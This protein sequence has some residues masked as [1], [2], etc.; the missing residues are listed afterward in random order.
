MAS[1]SWFFATDGQQHGPYSEDQFR[2]LIGRGDI[3]PDTYVWSEGMAAWQFAGD[4]P[5]LLSSGAPAVSQTGVRPAVPGGQGA[6]AFSL[7]VGVGE[8]LWRSLVLVVG[9]LLIIPVPW[10][11]VWYWRWFVSRVH[12]RQWPNLGFTGRPMDIW[13][14][15]AAFVLQVCATLIDN[16]FLNLFS[17]AVQL[18]LYWLLLR[19]FIANLSSNGQPLSLRFEGSFWG[20]FG[21]NILF[22]VSALTIIGWAW[23]SV[24][25]SRWIC[26]NISGSPHEIFFIATGWEILWRVLACGVASLFI[27]PIPWVARWYTGWYISQF[28][29]EKRSAPADV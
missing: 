29:L 22:V 9:F 27:I 15:L 26:R 5:G 17:A 14:Y 18:V 25:W 1:R 4:V 6:A 23:V 8:L 19:W 12:V 11:L 28:A 10:A 7:D 20:Y 24:A 16:Q 13:W 3:R 21:W 2:D